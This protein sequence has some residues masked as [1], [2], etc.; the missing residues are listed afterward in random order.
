[1]VHIENSYGMGQSVSQ[2]KRTAIGPVLA[3]RQA[4]EKENEM[5]T[6]PEKLSSAEWAEH[7]NPSILKGLVQ[8]L[9]QGEL[10]WQTKDMVRHTKVGDRVL[11][12][13]SGSGATSLHLAML[14]RICT[15]LDF[16]QPCLDLASGAAKELG[17]DLRT[18][19]ADATKDLPFEENAFDMVFQ[20]GLLEHFHRE[21][22]IDLL[23]KW[24]R[25]G[26]RMV[27]IIP[28]ASSLAYRLG[29]ARMEKDGTWSYGMELP[30]YSLFSEFAEANFYVT[31]E[32]TIGEAHALN[33]LPKFHPVRLALLWW[34]RSNPCGDNCGQGY[35]LVTVG[36]KQ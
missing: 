2:R 13:G 11:E 15:A 10:N 8:S 27:S 36:E 6:N 35:L 24:G 33:F 16:A 20:A 1:L 21:E 31:S 26:K 4:P 7:Y 3:G 25:V 32:Y 22:R 28:N 29:K 17:C 12:I 18:V 34:L 30:Q 19:Y 23:K 5:M 14:G 9:Q